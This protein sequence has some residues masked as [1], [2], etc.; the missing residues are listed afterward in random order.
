MVAIIVGA[1]VAL[2]CVVGAMVFLRRK[3]VV[4]DTP[5][6]KALGVFIG[7]TELKGTAES[8]KPFASYMAG[9]A[10]VRYS[11]HV[12][13]HWSRTVTETY[14]DAQGHT[15]T[16]TRVESGWKEVAHGGESAP[17]YL[18]DDTGVIRIV[19]DGADI[20]EPELFDTTVGRAD[21]LY[22][23]KAPVGE[24]A[25]STH[26]RRFHEKGI[27]IHTKLYV[28]GQARER[29]DVVAAEIA[30]S[31]SGMFIISTRTEKQISSGFGVGYWVFLALG[32]VAALA[33]VLVNGLMNRHSVWPP[34]VVAAAGYGAALGLGWAWLVYNSMVNLHQRVEQAWAQ[35]D[36]Q[37]KR[38]HDLIPNL[39]EVVQGY[40]THEREVQTVV[41]DLRAQLEATPPGVQGP[42]YHGVLPELRAV[43]ERY[44]DLKSSELFLKLQNQLTETEQRIALARDYFNDIA[45]FYNARLQLVPDR[46]IA[47]MMRLKAQ[48]LITAADFERARVDVKLAE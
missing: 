22:F 29:Q 37:L 34:Y 42:D 46:Y 1:V 12:E 15:Q 17:F 23:A 31:K 9:K 43:V 13:E 48:T 33:G 4:D 30:H 32:L 3:R 6:S 44:P 35:V 39:V 41:T 27:P 19:P 47:A 14:Q 28:M 24:I 10:C 16:R 8:E 26:R 20:D 21:P 11:W 7:L 38:R 25:N 18:K 2:G 5:T 45:S 40:A 36:I